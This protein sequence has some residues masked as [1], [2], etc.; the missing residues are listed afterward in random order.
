M[1]YKP[2]VLG[3]ESSLLDFHMNS[4]YS[5]VKKLL[6][7]N[8]TILNSFDSQE[9]A[10][11]IDSQKESN[12]RDYNTNVTSAL[13]SGLLESNFQDE[14]YKYLQNYLAKL[15]DELN[16]EL[17]DY[18]FM[19]SI[20]N[21]KYTVVLR[22]NSFSLYEYY[23]EKG[24]LLTSLKSLLAK[25]LSSPLSSIQL[26]ELDHFQIEIFESEEYQKTLFLKKEMDSLILYST[27]GFFSNI[28]E[29][30][31]LGGELY[32]SKGEEF[33]FF[34]NSQEHAVVRQHNKI[35]K[36]E[37]YHKEKILTADELK[38]IN[39]STK[40]INNA[41]LE[42]GITSKGVIKILHAR[43]NEF[44]LE[45]GSQ[46][47]IVYSASSKE[48]D[49]IA[50]I[51][52]K[53]Q[54]SD[55][56]T[57]P[58]YLLLRTSQDVDNFFRTM[59][60]GLFDG[61]LINKNMYHP[62]FEYLG[63]FYD[64]DV[65]FYSGHLEQA[66]EVTLKREEASIIGF[67]EKKAK[68]N[69]PFSSIL[70]NEQA[71]KDELL[72]RFK[73]VDLSTPQQPQDTSRQQVESIAESLMSSA[74]SS[75][76]KTSNSLM[77]FGS[78]SGSGEKKSAFQL[79]SESAFSQE[80]K[81]NEPS[82]E[83]QTPIPQQAP[84]TP[85]QVSTSQEENFKEADEEY[86]SY[87]P[88]NE[89][90]NTLI[91]EEEKSEPI[92]DSTNIQ[93]S[94]DD[95]FTTPQTQQEETTYQNIPQQE[96][97]SS[98]DMESV[99]GNSSESISQKEISPQEEKDLLIYDNILATR[100]LTPT[101]ITISHGH[102]I[103]SSAISELSDPQNSY[104]VVAQEHE[105][106][107][108]SLNYILPRSSGYHEEAHSLINSAEDFFMITPEDESKGIVLNL[109]TLKD[110]IKEAILH[111]SIEKFGVISLIATSDD[112]PLLEE[113]IEYIEFIFIKDIT[114]SEDFESQKEI[115]LMFEKRAL[116][117][118]LR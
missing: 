95:F 111:D 112:I 114:N 69:S 74:N 46:K 38:L 110:E 37:I 61:I 8:D 5:N 116:M 59:N 67:E 16:V 109:S 1:N 32:Y 54:Y 17:K 115:L 51:T 83:N 49:K 21:T 72:N 41:L 77:S 18:S 91:D 11:F 79:L 86:K 20:S 65:I 27:F 107:N 19:S 56:A 66:L 14:F 44:P 90:A 25:Y 80:K 93:S 26:R 117:K 63:V 88:I 100:I 118:K 103:D 106:S 23:I 35:E 78:S 94:M 31:S 102:I 29:N 42:I 76:R 85:Q 75:M 70:D 39:N 82:S 48:Y 96:K 113:I 55:E 7:S 58:Q 9:V 101:S 30:I 81:M 22:S 6:I 57:N 104:I 60:E 24:A 40:H 68:S 84:T 52:S 73:N 97:V 87:P 4:Q 64:C 105:I 53:N 34:E 43:T 33:H 47:G 62:F 28:S 15:S 50:I 92:Q 2:I 71:K 99:L 36:K 108:K 89:V 13:N 12:P 10:A 98:F 3:S 45:S